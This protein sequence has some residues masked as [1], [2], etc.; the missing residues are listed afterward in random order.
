MDIACCK[1][2]L[3]QLLDLGPKYISAEEG[4]RYRTLLKKLPEYM[5]NSDGALKEWTHPD[6]EDNYD[7][8]HVSHLYPVWPG[9]EIGFESTPKLF[10]AAKVAAEKRGR[11]NGSA[12]GLAHMALIGARLKDAELV[13]GNLRFMLGSGFVLPSLCTFHNVGRIYNM[14]ML[15]SLPAVVLEALVY[16][17][18]GEIE[19]LPALPNSMA[20]GR[21]SGVACRNQTV[22]PKMEWNTV[23]KTVSLELTSKIDQTISIRVRRGIASVDTSADTTLAD[24]GTVLRV[25]LTANVPVAIELILTR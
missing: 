4:D 16:S 12:H 22:I 7:H 11:G 25:S 20:V 3:T 1:E 5:T 10:A 24:Q 9:H 21:I 23:E 17:K 15:N 18:P 8:R 2:V 14:D 19:L 6:L 13:E